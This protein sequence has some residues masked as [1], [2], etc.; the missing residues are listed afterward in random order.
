MQTTVLDLAWG[1]REGYVFISTKDPKTG[2]W[3]EH[4]FRWPKQRKKLEA[5]VDNH[6]DLNLYFAPALFSE[7]R[8]RE[9]YVLPVHTLWADLDE[10][11]PSRSPFEPTAAWESSPYRY[12][13]L[14]LL[15]HELSPAD[16]RELNKRMT[17]ANVKHG[18]DK[19]GWDLTQV[20]RLPGTTNYKY[21]EQPTVRLMWH[22]KRLRYDPQELVDNLSPVPSASGLI[23]VT[24]LD[25]TTADLRE[26]IW[27]YRQILG[28]KLWQLLF[29]PNSQIQEGERSDR[30]WELECRLLEANVPVSEVMRIVK[31]CPWNKFHGRRD[32]NKRILSEVLK[33]ERHVKHGTTVAPDISLPWVNYSQLLGKTQTG[34]GWMI[35][36]IWVNGSWG[37]IAGEPKT[38]KS[39]IATEMAVSVSSGFPMWDQFSVDKSGPVIIIQE[40]NAPWVMQDRL[41]KVAHA[42]GLLNTRITTL[43]NDPGNYI[44]EMP[45]ALPIRMLNNWG[46]DITLPEHQDMLSREVDRIRPALIILD[47]L[48]L[49]LGNKDVN[50]A[51]ELNEPL[52]WLLSLSTKYKTALILL[53]HWN[54]GG[55]NK[56]PSGGGRIMGSAVIYGWADSMLYTSEKDRANHVITLGREFRSYG[57]SSPIELQVN[58]SD[59]GQEPFYQVETVTEVFPEPEKEK[60]DL[61]DLPEA[62]LEYLR[63]NGWATRIEIGKGVGVTQGA[64]NYKLKDLERLGHIQRVVGSRGRGKSSSYNLTDMGKRKAGRL[65]AERVKEE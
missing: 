3:E 14:W 2:T 50:S 46:F 9:E 36:D 24:E 39:L 4:P 56:A 43:K 32:E 37:L 29:T 30:L 15:D 59:P 11:P 20:L 7:P 13:A 63:I 48:Y 62:I 22:K 49:M 12:Q 27:P 1:R 33:A 38:Y 35:R 60:V 58:M 65:H 47:P 6:E 51:Q 19:S 28:D 10:A 18:A 45:R 44:I 64:V 8:R 17:Y 41:V 61:S 55:S 16:A 42:K 25:V 52:K 54:K 57:Q 53:H 31:V 5:F 40:E 26:L 34:P 23:D 21:V